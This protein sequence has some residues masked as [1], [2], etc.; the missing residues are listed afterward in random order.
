MGQT[1]SKDA[2]YAELYSSYIQQQQNMIYQQQQQI[3]S[4][5][6]NNLQNQMQQQ[7]IPPNTLFQSDMNQFQQVQ[8]QQYQQP[9]QYQQAQQYQNQFS[10]RSQTTNTQLQL[11][12]AKNKLDPYK[13]LGVSKN[14]DEKTLKKS[15][16]KAAMKAH[17][18]RGGSPQAFQQVSIAFS[19]LQKKLKEKEN[20]H[21]HNELRGN[22]KDF[23]S[24][25]ANTP[26]L[27][28]KM[29]EKFDIDVFN[30]IY[31]QNKIPEVYDDGY[32]DW[33]NENPALE[34]GQTKMF[35]SGFNKD[36]FNATFENYKR[37]QAQKNPQNSLIKYKDPEVKMS[38]SN[39]DSIMTLGQGKITDFSGQ[40][41]NLTYTDYKQAFTDGSMLIDPTSVDTNGRANS[42][43]GI[44]AQR[45]NVSYQMTEQDQIRLAQQQALEEKTERDRVSRLNVYDKQ[46][47]EAY[48][49]I[50]SMLLR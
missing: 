48:E 42:V 49:K 10:S 33:I 32:G 22:A 46:H 7:Q 47:G 50:H 34:S 18:D 12:S 28:T 3:N 30:Q 39:S 14:Y 11:P 9:Q 17:P 6:N 29:T 37:E 13:I 2:Q 26:K 15:Y 35:Q 45:S 36:M 24:Q 8:A 44:K 38:I 41:D 16:L 40:S 5:F 27:N 21:S 23:F 43:K 20:S 4:L 31:E 19:L 25:Q 1:P